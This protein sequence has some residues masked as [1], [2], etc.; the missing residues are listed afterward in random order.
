M[1]A[2]STIG[3]PSSPAEVITA[4]SLALSPSP[5]SRA[6]SLSALQAWSILPGYYSYL[7]KIFTER[8]GAI[9]DGVRL[10]AL[11]QFK[12]GVDKYWRRTANNAI[13][14]EEKAS[15]RPQLLSMIDEPNR[16]I[17]KNL[18]VTIGKLARLDYGL[19]WNDLPQ[20]LLESLHSSTSLLTIHRSLLYLHAS[21][22][23]LSSNRIPRGRLLMKKITELA[24]SPLVVV[25]ES[26]LARSVE[27]IQRDGLITQGGGADVEE[28]EC[29]LLAFKCLR[30][31]TIYG[32][33]NPAENPVIKAFFVSTLP[34][35]TSLVQLRTS[36]LSSPSSSTASIPETPRLVYLTKY[37]IGYTK[38]YRELINHKLESFDQMGITQGVLE[39][40]WEVI[41]NATT[42]PSNH[43]SKTTISDSITSP[44]PTRFV[45][46]CLLLLKSTLSSWDGQN[47]LTHA[48]IPLEFIYSLFTT[49]I[50]KCL[51]LT[52][53][54]LEKWEADPEE[55]ING[56]EQDEGM[57]KWEFE[58][59]PCAEY[60]LRS[61]VSG[62]KEEMPKKL[63]A[64]LQDPRITN[65]KDLDG[66]LL[67]EA[68]YTAI[69]KNLGDLAGV[70]DPADGVEFE[71]RLMQ[72][73]V[74]EAASTGPNYRIIRRRIAWL[75]GSIV[76]EELASESRTL[77]YSL[78]IHLLSRNASTDQSIRLTAARSLQKC[79]TWNFDLEGFLPHLGNAIEEVVE[80]L[81]EVELS[82]TLMRLNQTLGVIVARVGEQIIPFAPKLIEILGT[83][84]SGAQEN[85][86]HFQ[87]SILV[88]ITRLA[89][90]LGEASQALHPQAGA[91]IQ[92][93]VDS[94]RP[95]HVYLQ[96][97]A[98]ELWQVLLRRSSTLTPE[99]LALLPSLVT[100]IGQG[101]D[102]LPRCLSIFESYLLLHA[103]K[104]L[105]LCSRE[106]FKSVSELLDGLRLEA[107]KIVL[108][109]MNTIFR[110]CPNPTIW[111]AALDE[112]GCFQTMLQVVSQ[113]DTSALI[114]TKYLCSIA[115]IILASSET[116][117]QLVASTAARTNTPPD[118][119]LSIILNQF[120][121]RLDNMSQGGQ[122]KL[123]ALALAE[124]VATTN[125]IV[126]SRLADL[127]A[128]WSGVLAQTEET[129]EGD[130]ELYHVSDDYGSEIDYDYA[131]TLE[132]QRKTALSSIDPVTAHKL[133]TFIG[134]KLSQAQALNGGSEAFHQQ[135]LGQVDPIVVEELVKR[136]EGK[137][138][139]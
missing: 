73:L 3:P 84:W 11:L 27:R 13:S 57:E 48:K 114:A 111:A 64:Y 130:A 132:T 104:V 14:A 4:L 61:V 12:N 18:A 82:D 37:T 134:Q 23:S 1:S 88:T 120:V 77:L 33:S 74:P 81:G 51:V 58:L 124:L 17:A 128:L 99:M 10:Q 131:E 45:I 59:R 87:T 95:S 66:L 22:K 41:N 102:I 76:H 63:A 53:E 50:E 86:P 39:L 16:V 93:S 46:P 35:F 36:L 79:D 44:Y 101:T 100:L 117:H 135:W 115:R 136:L 32:D 129:Q 97:D 118:H 55:F 123:V 137:L 70:V 29:A 20:A 106:L 116:F 67:K 2:S 78:I 113:N 43:A 54:E 40:V 47:P 15:I 107:V 71:T 103:S 52:R 133:S 119:L 7:V 49:L 85:Q 24:F 62:Y 21:I 90:A 125:P 122:R 56:E 112:S 28:I 25:H 30:F 6:Q 91:I 19:D 138:K 75:L 121:D 60:V 31:L 94:S 80:L 42:T 105:E 68:V 126:L 98:L 65:P 139:G 110:T 9:D 83:L 38:L 89:E 72:A 8:G 26:L 5:E 108:H 69:G 92:I 34:T 127:V 96:E 109:A